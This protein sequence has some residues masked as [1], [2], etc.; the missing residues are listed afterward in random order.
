MYWF[1]NDVYF[2]LSNLMFKVLEQYFLKFKYFKIIF[3]DKIKQILNF[4]S[5]SLK[6]EQKVYHNSFLYRNQK[7]SKI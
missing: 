2:Y 7:I 4:N 5:W 6:I 1:Y 3:V